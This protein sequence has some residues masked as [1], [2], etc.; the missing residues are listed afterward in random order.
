LRTFS[1]FR[2]VFMAALVSASCTVGP[3][4]KRPAVNAPPV[5]RGETSNETAKQNTHSLGDEKWWTVFHDE[6]L[7]KLI[8]A[9][10]QN[11]YDVRIAA[12]RILQ[13]QAQF[14]IT[15]ANQFPNVSAGAA[16]SGL[17]QPAAGPLPAYS[18]VS[19]QLSLSA[20]W[21]PDFWGRYRR[22]TEAARANL[23]ATEWG[24][25]AVLSTLV[26]NLAT[27]YFQLREFDLEMDIARRTLASR[28]ESLKLTQ[29]L[30]SGGATSMVDVRQAQQLVETAAE[31]IPD[32]ERQV[33]QQENQISTLIGESPRDITRG[34]VLT[35][36]PLPA[37][38]PGGLPS[39]LLERRPD[40]RQAEQQLIGANA[41]IGVARAQLFPQISLTG[42]GGLESLILH[43]LFA[44]S[45]RFWNFAASAAQPVFNAGSLRANVRLAEAAQQ[46]A[47]LT[48]EQS[49]Q[50]A[51]REVSDSLVGYQKF[52]DFRAH[53]ELLTVAAQDAANLSE[54]RYRGGVASY[55]EVL[56]NE[57]NYFSAELNLARARLSERLSLVQ[58]YNALGGGWEQ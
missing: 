21:N 15:R 2:F 7:Q 27:T 26:A 50:Q 56:T 23:A 17:R 52:R 1:S 6:E 29:T 31:S 20:S 58:I 48:Y 12:T 37:A 28:Q 13:A 40:I 41:E 9:G 53:Q 55:L 49:I 8:R 4:Y 42:E 25:R 14:T 51:F 44:G 33:A 45:S 32:I 19:D 38:V 16:V 47:L 34:R 35:E 10:L 46:Q 39:S 22:A 18:Y 3:N 57:T 36:E 11:N 5:F 30:E 43:N 24:R 54:T